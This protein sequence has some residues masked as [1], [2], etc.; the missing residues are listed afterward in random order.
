MS[1]AAIGGHAVREGDNA[2]LNFTPTG[3]EVRATSVGKAATV[4]I[5]VPSPANATDKLANYWVSC[6]GTDKE[7]YATEISINYG[8][9]NV[10]T[11]TLPGSYGDIKEDALNNLSDFDK[12]MSLPMGIN[13]TLKLYF[14]KD[15]AFVINSVSLGFMP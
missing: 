15:T 10:E 6:S 14:A 11:K 8:D 5:P 2:K 3:V 12:H 9:T 13:V 1:Y 7:A 4:Y